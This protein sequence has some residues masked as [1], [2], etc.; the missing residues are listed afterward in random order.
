MI[1][2]NKQQ[3]G[4]SLVETLV[5]ISLLLIIIVGPMSITSRT[6]KSSSFATEQIQAFFLAQEGL[7]LAQ[8]ARDDLMLEFFKGDITDP[9]G[10]FMDTGGTYQ[11]CRTNGCGL[12]WSSTQQGQLAAPVACAGGMGGTCR[13]YVRNTSA[14]RSMFT[15]S[16][17]GGNTV[18]PFTRV[19]RFDISGLDATREVKIISTVTWRTGSL[20]QSQMV[21]VDTYLYN[22]YATP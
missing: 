7:E 18:T 5:A 20:V 13:L 1:Y 19:I 3:S 16:A 4:F 17:G 11:Q 8:K 10:Q 12:E 14:A 21:E 15:H 22:T 2:Y 9:W 6:A